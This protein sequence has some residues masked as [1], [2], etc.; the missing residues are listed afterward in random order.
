MYEIILETIKSYIT[1][2]NTDYAILLDGDWGTGKTHFVKN[3]LLSAINKIDFD[4]S[5]KFDYVYISAAGI[6]N[7][8]QFINDIYYSL[9]IK[10]LSNSNDMYNKLYKKLYNN[11]K[12]IKSITSIM[13]EGEK[14]CQIISDISGVVIKELTFLDIVIIIDDIE[15][16]SNYL[17]IDDF[18]YRIFDNFLPKGIKILFVGNENE[19]RSNSNDKK[20]NY[21][22]IKEKVI[23]HTINIYDIDKNIFMQIINNIFEEIEKYKDGKYNFYT[24]STI[25]AHKAGLIE[26]FFKKKCFNIRVFLSYLDL[27]KKLFEIKELP[28]NNYSFE[29]ILLK[30]LSILIEIRNN[31]EDKV[32]N[33]HENDKDE[34]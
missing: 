26:I 1:E 13:P 8:E 30:L 17:E 18:L 10:K 21:F 5:N 7:I 25:D 33:I 23:K 3:I 31:D 20:S 24:Y 32:N 4:D 28:K 15:R 22:R 19:I 34:D 29:Q 11:R 6:N 27:S 12:I 16:I 9:T 2:K 14:L